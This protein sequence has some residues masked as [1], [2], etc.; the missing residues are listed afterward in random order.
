MLLL[1]GTVGFTPT[2]DELP[3]TESKDFI[4][5]SEKINFNYIGNGIITKELLNTIVTTTM[6]LGI[7]ECD[8]FNPTVLTINGDM[9]NL[10]SALEFGTSK[11][12]SMTESLQLLIIFNQDGS[13]S[14]KFT[15][16]N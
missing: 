8:T 1:I 6:E 11:E 13:V 7:K 4:W 16:F 9:D 5:K 10:V 14:S 12:C 2:K 15:T 3:T